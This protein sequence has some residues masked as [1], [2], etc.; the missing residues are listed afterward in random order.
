[1]SNF[2]KLLAK[3]QPNIREEYVSDPYDEQDMVNEVADSSENLSSD[4]VNRIF[5]AESTKGS[6]LMNKQGSSAKGN[7]QFIDSTR[8]QLLNKL[9][10][11]ENTEIPVNPLRKDA[12]LMKTYLNDNENAL[13]NSENGPIDPNL[14]NLYMAHHYGTQGALNAINDPNKPRSKARFKH[15]KA[16]LNKPQTKTQKDTK[17][18]R[19]LL[20]LLK[21]E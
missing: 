9:K 18:A 6:Q 17:P 19:D 8:E 12:L 5:D 10:N 21:E 7:F 14:E 20:D 16:Q 15:T 13:L 1:M 2:K 4:D 3:L 11:K